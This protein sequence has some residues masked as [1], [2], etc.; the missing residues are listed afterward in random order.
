MFL[1]GKID[2]A[3]LTRDLSAPDAAA[4]RRTHGFEPTSIAVSGGSYRHFGF[5]DSVAVI[6]NRDNPVRGLTLAQ[7]DAIFSKSRHRGHDGPA[8]TWGDVG[9]AAWSDRP[10][11]IVGHGAW[12]SE[13]SA[14]ATFIRRRVM[15]ID[16]KRGAWRDDLG[17][18]DGG[19]AIVSERVAADRY[20]I[21]FTGM[22]HLLPDTKTVA[23]AATA[24]GPDYEASYENVAR[25]D[26]PLARVFYLVVAKPLER[27]LPPALSELVRF[28]LS[29]EGQRVVLE[30]GVFLPLRASQAAASLQLLQSSFAS[31]CATS[32]ARSGK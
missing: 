27:A 17:P 7:L 13:E 31:S 2:F 30:Q 22:G 32:S 28:L 19:D 4:F 5:V 20:A 29:R 25:A 24:G 16:G 1:D 12:A 23:I 15:E 14:R 26:F 11:H 6:V 18:A 9:V 3:F 8:S 21:G 10:I